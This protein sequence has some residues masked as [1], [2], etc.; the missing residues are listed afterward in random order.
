MGPDALDRIN[1]SNA[2]IRGNSPVRW[3]SCSRFPG[4]HSCLPPVEILISQCPSIPKEILKRHCPGIYTTS[5][6][7]RYRGRILLLCILHVSSSYIYYMHPPHIYTT[8][9]LLLCIL[10]VSSFY[11][12]YMYP[13]PIYTTCIDSRYRG[14][15]TL[16]IFVLPMS[17]QS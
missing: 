13:P 2:P 4:P 12:Y 15:L 11:I 9:I 10:H 3:R 1:T 16:R 6:E 5:I 8:C 14:R 7:S 17:E